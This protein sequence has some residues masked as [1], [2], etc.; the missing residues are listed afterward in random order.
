M[1]VKQQQC[2]LCYL[3]F[4]NG[5]IDG[6]AGAATKA[7]AAKFQ[8]KYGLN[9]D[10]IIGALT[11]QKL[12]DAVNGIAQP[13]DFWSSVKYFKQDE[14]KCKCGCGADDIEEELVQVAERVREHFGKPITVSSGLRC[15]KH[16]KKVGGV[17]NSRHLSGKAMDFN[18]KG[19]SASVVLAYVKKQPEIRY[20]YA[21]NKDYVHMDIN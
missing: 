14:F 3:G 12:L 20:A 2:L 6:K 17:S 21:I 13:I 7:A 19:V 9:A 8:K 16:N 11:E 10:G 4:Y 5:A 15:V 18:V 1:T